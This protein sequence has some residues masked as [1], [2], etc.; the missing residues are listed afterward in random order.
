MGKWLAG[1]GLGLLAFGGSC[2]FAQGALP[3]AAASIRAQEAR[4][5]AGPGTVVLDRASRLDAAVALGVGHGLVIRAPLSLGPGATVRLR[6]SNEVR[7]LA[8]LTADRGLNLFVAEGVSDVAVRDCD[9]TV[10]GAPGGVLLTATRAD[11]VVVTGNQ[12]VNLAIFA[13]ANAGGPQSQTTDVTL[14]GNSSTFPK[15]GG[16]IGIYL[17]YVL[18][19]TV[20][21]NRFRG[22]GHGIE[23]WGGNANDGWKSAAEVTGAGEMSITGN[24]CWGAGGACVWGSM[25]VDVAVTGNTAVGCGD[26][27]FDTEGGV[28]NLFTGNVARGCGNGCYA[29]EFESEDATFSGNFAYADAK[30]PAV[31]LVLIKHPSG[32]PFSHVRLT[33]SGN[34]LACGAVCTAF[35]SEGEDG[36]VFAGNTLTNGVVQF[37]N[38]T[39]SVVIRGN[40]LRFTAALGAQAAI[41]G[42]TLVNGHH[43]EIAENWISNEGSAGDGT[44]CIS[45]SWSDFNSADEM[46]I[47]RNTCLGFATGISTETNGGNPGAPRALWF[48]EGNQFSGTAEARQMV[49]LRRRGNESYVSFPVVAA[50]P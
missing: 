43:S 7:C 48:L 6:G 32:R 38:Y 14:T 8:P 24:Q 4:L 10:M 26:V 1:A 21:D 13:T 11:R 44:T 41:S 33:V 39:N 2:L 9:V 16:P 29:A 15:G 36:L 17:T 23:W 45:Q 22:T 20:A 35:Y 47:V 25:G 37:A 19:A 42:P 30:N 31:A 49:H 28:R 27:C 40:T 5:G 50:H 34:T 12:L 18:R 3:D 46:R